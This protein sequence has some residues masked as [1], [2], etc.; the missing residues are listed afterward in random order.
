MPDSLDFPAGDIINAGTKPPPG[1]VERLTP[2]PSPLLPKVPWWAW[3]A[4][5]YVL[6]K[7]K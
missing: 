4:L 2:D 3:I 1:A 7:R 6:G 5:G